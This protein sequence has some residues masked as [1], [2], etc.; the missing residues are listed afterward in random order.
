MTVPILSL[1]TLFLGNLPNEKP[2]GMSEFRKIY[3]SVI[4]LFI[5][6]FLDSF[7]LLYFKPPKINPFGMISVGNK[8]IST[9]P[10]LYLFFPKQESNNLPTTNP[11]GISSKLLNLFSL[12]PG[13]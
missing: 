12:L 5:H 4:S 1:P 7:L 10:L 9:K 8:Y 11:L 13:V 2:K 6:I 3:D